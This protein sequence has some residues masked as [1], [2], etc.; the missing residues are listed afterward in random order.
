MATFTTPTN[1]NGTELR[2]ELNAAGVKISD[3]YN[4]IIVSGDD[5]ILDIADKDKDKAQSV[6]TAHNGTTVA[7]EPSL[8]D[9]LASIGLSI[10]ELKAA[11]GV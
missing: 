11:L 6:V 3:S 5:L 9:K 10:D 8:A 1:L 7:P 2:A 4:A